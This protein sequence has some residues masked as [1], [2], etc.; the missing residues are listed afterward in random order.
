M[1]T[2]DM[3]SMRLQQQAVEV[4]DDLLSFLWRTYFDAVGGEVSSDPQAFPRWA[5]NFLATNRPGTTFPADQNVGVTLVSGV[6]LLL[7]P[8]ANTQ[9]GEMLKTPLGDAQRAGV[10]ASFAEQGAIPMAGRPQKQSGQ[11]D[12]RQMDA[13]AFA[14]RGGVKEDAKQGKKPEQL[15]QARQYGREL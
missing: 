3:G 13:K 4:S 2:G 5:R 8:V 12:Y 15:D 10:P 11:I 7:A 6:S 14:N 1:S 9:K